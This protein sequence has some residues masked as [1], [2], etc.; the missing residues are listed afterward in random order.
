MGSSIAGW[1][2]SSTVI[3]A[4]SAAAI[5]HFFPVKFPVTASVGS[6]IEGLSLAAENIFAEINT[7]KEATKKELKTLNIKNIFL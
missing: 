2:I 7:Y 1:A 3:L 5:Y 4:I 6:S